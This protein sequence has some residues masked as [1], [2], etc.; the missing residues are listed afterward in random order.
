MRLRY[1]EQNKGSLA[2]VDQWT[3]HKYGLSVFEGI[4]DYEVNAMTKLLFIY[5]MDVD[6]GM[7]ETVEHFP[8]LDNEYNCF[9][10]KKLNVSVTRGWF[11]YKG[12]L[13]AIP[14]K[15]FDKFQKKMKK[16]YQRKFSLKKNPINL[17]YREITG[18]FKF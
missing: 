12:R 13:F 8:V 2:I 5:H 6:S 16:R 17:R 4:K 15:S 11:H 10:G 1:S 14:N 3:P 7:E 9:I 18:K